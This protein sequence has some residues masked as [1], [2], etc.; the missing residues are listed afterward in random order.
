M[1]ERAARDSQMASFSLM[2]VARGDTINK[3]K[4]RLTKK[5]TTAVAVGT[6]L[7]T[8]LIMRK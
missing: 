5:Q 2:Y 4:G 3:W 7:V 1:A 6:V 8:Y